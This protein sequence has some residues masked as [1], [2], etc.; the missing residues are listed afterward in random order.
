MISKE[1]ITMF[2]TSA[3]T[4]YI[5]KDYISATPLFFKT[6]FAIQDFILLEKIGRSPKD[7]K[8]YRKQ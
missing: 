1:Q 5:A 4:L 6:W 2:K 3:E 8:S 7:H